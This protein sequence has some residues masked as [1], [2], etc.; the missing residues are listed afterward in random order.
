MN[1]VYPHFI[2]KHL[3][4]V[5]ESS[6]VTGLLD[7]VLAPLADPTLAARLMGGLGNIA[8]A[9]PTST[10]WQLSRT[11]AVSPALTAAFDA[12]V[13]GLLGR[14]RA[15]G[16]PAVAFLRAWDAFSYEFGS[17]S[18]EEWAAMPQT[19]ETHPRIPLA[20]IERMRLQPADRD[21]QKQSQ[22]LRAEREQLTSELRERLAGQ[23]EQLGQLELALKLIG[24]YMPA[25]ELSKTNTIRVLHEA[26]LPMRELAL[27]YVAAGVFSAAEDITMLREDEL[28]SLLADPKLWVPVIA[29]RWDWYRQ[30]EQLEPP[31]I[32]NTGEV[33][34][35]TS[36]PKKED[37]AVAVA[38]P[39]EILT[40]L[41]AC[42]GVATGTARV[43]NDPSEATDLQPGEI[44]VAPMTDPG[45]T[46]LFTSAE[47]VVVNVGAALSHAAIVSRELGIPCVLGVTHATKRIPNGA[48]LSVDG[49][50]G[51]VTVL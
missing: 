22:R 43:I 14:L 2:Y 7:Q 9:A 18:T 48:R 30:L 37:P 11:V 20:L 42:P 34:P 45:W 28:D 29:E 19:W 13:D 10:L 27:R 16:G 35:V 5:Y 44:L 50:S 12:G 41:P 1:E 47:A 3:L 31:Y 6:L 25:R 21:P 51:L 23:R 33:P 8:S 24:I 36:W 39:G 40:G 4:S 38:Q 46:P 32:V 26:R 17:R 15:S 49:T